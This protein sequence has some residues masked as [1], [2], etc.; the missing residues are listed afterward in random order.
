MAI[1]FITSDECELLNDAR[2]LLTELTERADRAAWDSQKDGPRMS[3]APDDY[4]RVA[5][6][7]E[8][9]EHD[10]FNVLN[11]INA[12]LA[13]GLTELELHMRQTAVAE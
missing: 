13:A 8:H 2:K 7:C 4:G 10:I 11:N 6:L 12:H 5:A 1:H 3:R 9:A